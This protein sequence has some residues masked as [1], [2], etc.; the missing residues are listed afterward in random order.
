[1]QEPHNNHYTNNT[2]QCKHIAIKQNKENRR[3]GVGFI[4]ISPWGFLVFLKTLYHRVLFYP[5]GRAG[6][7]ASRGP[8]FNPQW[9]PHLEPAWQ[10]DRPT[11]GQQPAQQPAKQLAQQQAQQTGQQPGQQP[12]QQPAQ[13]VNRPTTPASQHTSKPNSQA[14]SQANSQTNMQTGQ[15]Q[16]QAGM[17]EHGFNM[18]NFQHGFSKWKS[19]V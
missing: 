12:A 14:N 13:Q 6:G 4:T 7:L 17:Q 19:D 11:A 9:S 1:M 16:T 18:G 2:K 5:S 3:E 15:Q 8:R 10:T